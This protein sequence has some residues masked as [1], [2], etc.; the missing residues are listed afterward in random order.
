VITPRRLLPA[1]LLLAACGQ[2]RP[3]SDGRPLCL[4]SLGQPSLVHPC[5]WADP[6]S[7][8]FHGAALKA[9]AWNLAACQ[10]CHGQDFKGGTSGQSCYRCH[11]NGPTSCTTC[12]AQPPATG[13]HAVHVTDHKIDCSTCHPTPLV[14]NQAPHLD[15][16][17]EVSPSPGAYVQ[18]RCSGTYCHGGT[19]SDSHAQNTTPSWTG[20]AS[21]AACGTCHGLPPSS[22]S[23]SDCATCHPLAIDAAGNLSAKH[24]DGAISLGDESGGCS[25]CHTV[26]PAKLGGAHLGHLTAPLGLRG[27]LQCSD[28]HVVPTVPNDAMHPPPQLVSVPFDGTRCASS[29]C[30]LAA[31]PAWTDGPNAAACGTCHAVPPSDAPHT[32]GMVLSDCAQ[33]HPKTMNA[34]GAFVSGGA[35]MNGVVD[36]Q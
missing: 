30:H 8:D 32:S 12:H 7:S 22:H 17:V 18:G 31:T 5:G 34:S 26:D 11:D 2:A 3:V 25:A 16:I 28:C 33:C 24:L 9:S 21:Q 29:T 19:F 6:N 20:G 27:P 1:A 14:Y 13:A 23:R 10:Q 36:A 4:D 15:G 35:H